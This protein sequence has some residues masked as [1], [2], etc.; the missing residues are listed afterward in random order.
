MCCCGICIGGIGGIG[1][2][3]PLKLNGN[4]LG[5]V[6]GGSGGIMIRGMNLIQVH[7]LLISD[8]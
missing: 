1:I 5:N 6:P 2:G 7:S 4:W 3:C 8:F